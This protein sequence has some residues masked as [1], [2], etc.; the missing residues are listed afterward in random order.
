MVTWMQEQ[1][2]GTAKIM[3]KFQN[4]GF[5]KVVHD[6]P[7]LNYFA[8]PMVTGGILITVYGQMQTDEDPPMKFTQTFHLMS[9]GG[10][11]SFFILNE[12]FELIL[13]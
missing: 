10:S 12:I 8:Q 5:G 4:L 6:F 1:L 2:Q 7:N 13:F 9:Q 3:E 11:G